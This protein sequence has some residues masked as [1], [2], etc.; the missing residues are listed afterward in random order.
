MIPIDLQERIEKIRKVR[1]FMKIIL[2]SKKLILLELSVI[3]FGLVFGLE[4][5]TIVASAPVN[6]SCP[7][8]YI[9]F[10]GEV[11][12]VKRINYRK[13]TS[14][15]TIEEPKEFL[16]T[17]IKILDTKIVVLKDCELVCPKCNKDNNI[18]SWINRGEKLEF[19]FDVSEIVKEKDIIKA[20]T[21]TKWQMQRGWDSYYFLD[22]YEVINKNRK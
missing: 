1:L 13:I 6:P 19:L 14:D 8:F 22:S 2:E 9:E 16:Q 17:I 10:K 3:F 11:I 15:V 20:K 12:E 7:D 18:Q 4:L 21:I 5:N